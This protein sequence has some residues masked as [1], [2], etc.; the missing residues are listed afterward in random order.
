MDKRVDPKLMPGARNAVQVCLNVAMDDRVWI[1]TDYAREAIGYALAEAAREQGATVTLRRMEEFGKR[2]F[3][4]LPDE[5]ATDLQAISPTVTILA[6]SAQAGEIRFRLP[7][8]RFLRQELSVRHGHMI[9][10]TPALM[11]SGMM[12]DYHR[13]AQ[14]TRQVQVL[15]QAA[16]EVHVT[17]PLG[18]DLHVTLDNDRYR[19]MPFHGMYHTPG[20][21]GN[22]PEGEACTS[23]L[24]VNGVLQAELLG[25]IFC[26]KY[27]LLNPPI[28][29]YIEDGWVME[30]AAADDRIAREVWDYLSGTTNGRRV[31]EFAVGTNEAL[32][33][34]S[35]NLLQDEKHPGVHLAFGHPL[36]EIT[37]AE[38]S[39]D[40]H[41]DAITTNCSI[42]VDGK[43][44]M[45]EGNFLL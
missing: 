26:E 43:V 24:N 45:E 20:Q 27:G 31:G 3:T 40:I 2:P 41:V 11:Q 29:F 22:L 42:Q 8:A 37:G 18:T 36:P 32:N 21:W 5:M 19:W 10:V 9:G 7:L 13:V 4:V 39:S 12:A 35:G 33:A 25:D 23:P 44:L 16:H 14:L 17:S 34:L 30:V 28:T 1:L 38:W 15:M 6:T